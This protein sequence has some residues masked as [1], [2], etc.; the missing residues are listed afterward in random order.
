MSSKQREASTL[1]P[2]AIVDIWE[3]AVPDG[4]FQPKTIKA[5]YET[6]LS[7]CSMYF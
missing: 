2:Q 3:K 6:L 7:L 4:A 5:L 1:T